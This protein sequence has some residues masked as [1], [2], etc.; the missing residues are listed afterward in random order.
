MQ[1]E[2]KEWETQ[3]ADLIQELVRANHILATE[4][5]VDSY[6][7]ISARSQTTPERYLLSCSRSPEQVTAPDI[8][9]FDFAG[10]PT[11]NT[12]R[13]PYLERFIH[14]AI[15]AARSD[16]HAIVHSHATSVL[17][18][19]VTDRPLRPIMHT[20]GCIGH[21]IPK[22]DIRQQFGHTDML[23]RSN[24]TAEDL[25]SALGMQ[26]VV[27]MRGHGATIVGA[28]IR[29]ATI[30]AVYLQISASVTLQALQLGAVEFL[31]DEEIAEAAK[32]FKNDSAIGRV[33]ENLARRAVSP[34]D[35]STG[36]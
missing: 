14:G 34:H 2:P 32:L 11:W 1:D 13:T 3:N 15:Y 29:R 21:T 36:S 4:N 17:P 24:D 20:A 5:V 12:D 30:T 31:S 26:S 16:V 22:W 25:A 19:S 23:V 9:E 28:D 27:L 33:W 10:Q 18:F 6:G 35:H 8:M 7:H